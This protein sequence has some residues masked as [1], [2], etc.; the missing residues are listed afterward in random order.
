MPE[1]PLQGQLVDSGLVAGI[2]A[3]AAR[4]TPG[5]LRL[6]T[7]R[8]YLLARLRSSAVRSWRTTAG[9]AARRPADPDAPALRDGVL[10][11]ISGGAARIDLGVATD[12]AFNAQEVTTA[13]R[14]RIARAVASA[15]IRTETVNVTVLAIEP[16]ADR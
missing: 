4:E 15:G 13:L 5:V 12:L 10:A 8:G 7:D 2:A 11:V 9:W 16:R 14:D 6:E 3:R 1:R